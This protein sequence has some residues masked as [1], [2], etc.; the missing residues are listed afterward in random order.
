MAHPRRR[1]L[2]VVALTATAI[3]AS[4]APTSFA[5]PLRTRNFQTPS[6]N[7][8]CHLGS[9]EPKLRCDI[10]SGLNPEPQRPCD[11]DW[12]GLLLSR[13]NR[14]KPNC[15]SDTIA[16]PDTPVLQYGRRWERAGRVC[17]SRRTG[18]HCWNYSGYHFKLS[19]DDWSR[20]YTP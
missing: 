5:E 9:D 2:V 6:G 17:V 1:R 14:A 11:F 4:T 20:W 3:F 19:R 16:R 15:A 7:I 13:S 12:V 10:R 8:F 18:L